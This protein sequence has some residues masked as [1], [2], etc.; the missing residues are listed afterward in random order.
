LDDADPDARNVAELLDGI[1]GALARAQ[2]G[3]DQAQAGETISLDELYGDV[4]RRTGAR[5]C[6]GSRQPDRC[7]TRSTASPSALILAL[8]ASRWRSEEGS[9]LSIL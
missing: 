7:P 3:R 8:V 6:R 4:S 2:L 1:P 9:N 5:R